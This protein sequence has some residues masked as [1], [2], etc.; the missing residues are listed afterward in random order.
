MSVKYLG[1]EVVPVETWLVNSFH[2]LM[3][4][5]E[6]ARFR[7]WRDNDG[8]KWE[9]DGEPRDV[10]I[11]QPDQHG[12]SGEYRMFLADTDEGRK[13]VLYWSGTTVPVLEW[14][15]SNEDVD[16][17][18]DQLRAAQEDLETIALTRSYRYQRRYENQAN[19]IGKWAD[20]IEHAREFRNSLLGWDWD[21]ESG[22]I[23]MYEDAH[24]F[25]DDQDMNYGLSYK[26]PKFSFL[27][28]QEEIHEVG[29]A[30]YLQDVKVFRVETP[31]GEADRLSYAC[32]LQAE[33]ALSKYLTTGELKDY[34]Y[35]L[36]K[37]LKAKI[38]RVV[39]LAIVKMSVSLVRSGVSSLKAQFLAK[40]GLPP[41]EESD[42]LWGA[43]SRRTYLDHHMRT[44]EWR[45]P[46]SA[47][48]LAQNSY[49]KGL[50][51]DHILHSVGGGFGIQ[52]TSLFL[53]TKQE[54]PVEVSNP[55]Q[56]TH[57]KLLKFLPVSEGQIR[58]AGTYFY[59]G[60]SE[61]WAH[62]VSKGHPGI[63]DAPTATPRPEKKKKKKKKMTIGA[64]SL[65][66]I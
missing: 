36:E 53:Q 6:L 33:L 8:E 22:S 56:F 35:Y 34:D 7:Y 49:S 58:Q 46:F 37:K 23:I 59:R 13:V 3:G 16:Y 62:W 48:Q 1:V 52:L 31:P 25:V 47:D 28:E 14:S 11:L 61:A 40:L 45:S 60:K 66:D 54:C 63:Y 4:K 51:F 55:G 24:V 57:Q 5:D 18:L 20:L 26:E 39:G 43:A 38:N 12:E 2:T 17:Y 9:Y 10:P 44:G 42:R 15:A 29:G 21:R 65:M 50:V 30:F 41:S 19:I 27:K 32:D 64:A